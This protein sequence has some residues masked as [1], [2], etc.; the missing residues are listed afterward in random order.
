MRNICL[1]AGCKKYAYGSG[2]CCGHYAQ[3][4]KYGYI[5]YEKLMKNTGRSSHKLYNT[6]LS[7]KDRCNNP[8]NRCYKNYGGRGIK[9]CDRWQEHGTGFDNFLSDM[10][11]RPDGCSLDRIDNDG[12]YCP[13]NCKWSTKISQNLN[14]RTNLSEPYISTRL[15][16]AKTQ[17]VVRIKDL[18]DKTGKTV[19]TKVRT[20]LDEAIKAR[21]TLLNDMRKSGQR[22]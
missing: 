10:G 15:R 12:D 19:R 22:G 2:Y 17:Y 6:W 3:Y 14:K 4:K 5:K 18:R 1:V 7:M 11:D 16:G 21:D 8:H 20:S 13:E 9:V